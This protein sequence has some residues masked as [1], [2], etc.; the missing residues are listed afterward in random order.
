MS[1]SERQL[2]LSTQRKYQYFIW[3]SCLSDSR[4]DWVDPPL[5]H[6]SVKQHYTG[7]RCLFLDPSTLYIDYRTSRHVEHS[8]RA[9]P[10]AYWHYYLRSPGEASRPRRQIWSDRPISKV[11]EVEVGH[12]G[13]RFGAG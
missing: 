8:R 6:H 7:R 1:S 13:A 5:T 12:R 3:T 11:V 9:L 4:W 2:T 10:K